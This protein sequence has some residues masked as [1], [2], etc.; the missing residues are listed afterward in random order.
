MGRPADSSIRS[1]R[2]TKRQASWRARSVP[3]VVLP[4]P[5]NPARQKIGTRGRPREGGAVVTSK[6]REGQNVGTALIALQDSNCTTVGGEFDLGQAGTNGAKQ[7]TKRLQM[8]ADCT[9][10]I[11]LEICS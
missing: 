5:M 3:T 2:S 4:E 6:R 1:S 8:A 7:R 9:M 11:R 10:G